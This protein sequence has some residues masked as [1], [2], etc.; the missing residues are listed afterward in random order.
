MLRVLSILVVAWCLL[1]AASTGS[2]AATLYAADG[3]GGNPSSLYILNPLNGAVVSVVGSI[4]FGVT[5]LAVHPITGDLYGSTANLDPDAAGSF[6][7]INKA[8]GQG[9]LIGS[10]GIAGTLADITFTSDGTAYGWA[11]PNRALYTVNLTT[12]KATRVGNVKSPF[13][14]FGSGIAASATVLYLAGGGG[15]GP[16]FQVDRTT[17]VITNIGT[18]D[19]Q[20]NGPVNGMAFGPGGLY[21]LAISPFAA[22]VRT[23]LLLIDPATGHVT[24][25]GLSVLFGDAIAFDP[26]SFPPAPTPLAR[27]P[28][29]S[30]LGF[31]VMAALLA[32]VAIYHVQRR[33]SARL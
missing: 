7:R 8:T 18:L 20:L 31:A 13:S 22:D 3:A 1:V 28:T 25:L 32:V 33:R 14:T 16:L 2:D 12:G 29:L 24:Q 5:G 30:D 26:P 15:Q 23:W 21:A 17:G 4:G 27:I 6:I 11:Q 9:T 10:Y 19:W